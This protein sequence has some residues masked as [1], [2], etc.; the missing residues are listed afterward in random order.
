V[1]CRPLP[2]V[3]SAVVPNWTSQPWEHATQQSRP[4]LGTG[5]AWHQLTVL[6]NAVAQRHTGS[7]AP[8]GPR[9][10]IQGANGAGSGL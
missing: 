8:G 4:S 10:L 2:E 7:G 9:L 3:A 6:L 5:S 1:Q